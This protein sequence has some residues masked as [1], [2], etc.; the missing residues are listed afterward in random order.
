[1][2][3]VPAECVR[4]FKRALWLIKIRWIA[5]V[6]LTLAILLSQNFLKLQIPYSNLYSV[7]VI[8]LIFNLIYLFGGN[9]FKQTLLENK[10]VKKFINLQITIDFILLTIIL[11]YSGG[12]ENP[13]IVFFIFHMLV[14]SIS[15]SKL[16]S[17][18]Q[19]TIA[20]VLFISLV[21]LENSNR[22]SHVC[23]NDNICEVLHNDIEYLLIAIFVFTI[24]SY[25]V[26]YIMTTIMDQI[27]RQQLIIS[28]ANKELLKKDK[29][30]N[31]YVQRVTHDIKGHLAVVFSSLEILKRKSFGPINDDY[32]NIIQRAY[33]R[34]DSLIDFI[35]ELLKITNLRLSNQKDISIFSIPETIQKS[36]SD[37]EH[38]ASDKKMILQFNIDK[39]V[40]NFEG[41]AFSVEEAITNLLQNAIKYTPEN[42][43]VKLNSFVE[44]N[45]IRIDI[46]DTGIG[47]PEKDL[48]RIF[49]EFFRASNVKR[50][51]EGGGLGLALVKQIVKRQKGEISV[52]STL[53]EG[54]TFTIKL[55]IE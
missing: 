45:F 41:E 17:Y 47:I 51:Y 23:L 55:P 53:G 28:D 29:I 39:N 21:F 32:E 40:G 5:I 48:D 31:E 25:L 27:R 43:T 15:L 19:T 34:T 35:E 36:I 14:A 46:S 54:S 18:I 4:L 44:N 24:S 10:H 22:I 3:Q 6:G 12:I 37:C 16:D 13:F 38:L 50:S 8:L 33:K 11:H 49:D 2:K 7:V 20:L 26:V 52:Q 42:G 1:M 30:K 9:K